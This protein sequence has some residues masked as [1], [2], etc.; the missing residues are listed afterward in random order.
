[1]MIRFLQDQFGSMRGGTIFSLLLHVMAVLITLFGLP[2][3][4]TQPPVIEEPLVVDLVPLGD[5]TNPPPKQ[6]PTPEPP[7][8][9]QKPEPKPEAPKPEPKTEP[10]K[11]APPPPAPPPKP[12]HAKPEPPKPE[13]P[14]P[15]PPK[16]EPAPVP[17]PEPK[18]EPKKEEPK[19]PAEKPKDNFDQLLK[20]V[21]K[22]KQD[23]QFDQL[24]K[25]MDKT[26]PAP[27]T[28]QKPAK[29]AAAPQAA[30]NVKGSDL[31][32]P[33]QPLSMTELDMIKAQIQRCW[34]VPAGAKDAANLI[35]PIRVRLQPD[36]TVISADFAGDMM[37]YSSDG[38]YRAA[39]DSARRAVLSCSP[40][41]A[42]PTKYETW[43]D[44]TLRFNPQDMLQ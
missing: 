4:H 1:M 5:I 14:K 22:L 35:I 32:N 19:K 21:E 39:S 12:E 43:K 9:D 29:N 8:E 10:P 34:N 3:L 6:K 11:P 13:P 7:R 18:P 16:P 15:E 25:T 40:L 37:R 38:F 33:D 42:P 28:D 2:F 30:S 27:P 23:E 41:K 44:L 20:S 17:K 26:K 24:L 31:H 36:G